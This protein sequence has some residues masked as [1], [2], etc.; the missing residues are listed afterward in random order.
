MSR[1]FISNWLALNSQK[2]DKIL[3][4]CEIYDL[5]GSYGGELNLREVI[6]IIKGAKE[7]I[8][9]LSGKVEK[10]EIQNKDYQLNSEKKIKNNLSEYRS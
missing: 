9:I 2:I 7:E 1:I 8:N 10:L 5:K 3:R 6:R 4:E